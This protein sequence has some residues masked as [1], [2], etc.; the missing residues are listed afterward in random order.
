MVITENDA[1]IVRKRYFDRTPVIVKP[2]T[3]Q[4]PQIDR[5]KFLCPQDLTFGQLC[6]IVR[7]RIKIESN[8]ALFLFLKGGTIP[9]TNT[10]ISEL[11]VDRNR[12]SKGFL[13]ITYSLEN[14]FGC[15]HFL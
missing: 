3:P 14:T 10:A 12:D 9:P 7:K 2:S 13:P 6:F 8:E 4:T 1:W 5:G 15:D 11:D